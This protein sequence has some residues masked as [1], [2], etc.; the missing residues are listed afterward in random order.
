MEISGY[1][2]SLFLETPPD[3]F[4][5]AICM[6]V[7]RN[8]YQCQNGHMFCRQCITRYL[9]IAPKCPTCKFSLSIEI[10]S[11]CLVVRNMVGK[12]LTRCTTTI[13][14]ND[15]GVS[16]EWRGNIDDLSEHAKVCEFEIIQ[17]ANEGCDFS[18][19]RRFFD[20]HELECEY[21]LI[22]CQYCETAIRRCNQISHDEQCTQRPMDCPNDCGVQISGA[23]DMFVH[24]GEC[25]LQEVD[26]PFV[27]VGCSPF[28][29]RR[30][31]RRDLGMH[32]SDPSTTLSTMRALVRKIG[33]LEEIRMQDSNRIRN[34]EH[35]NTLL[36]MHLL[37][38]QDPDSSIIFNQEM[39]KCKV[40]NDEIWST[41]HIAWE[42]QCTEIADSF[43]LFDLF[44]PKKELIPDVF[45]C[46]NIDITEPLGP[47][48]CYAQLDGFRRTAEYSITIFRYGAGPPKQRVDMKKWDKN[49]GFGWASFL[50]QEEL[51]SGGYV[52]AD[53]KMRILLTISMEP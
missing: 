34:L 22:V 35:Q 29:P 49:Q 18:F 48:R 12:L 50:S 43:K 36:S 9:A 26:C 46:I 20:Y 14:T 3:D 42:V 51:L 53:F 21:K 45:G 28:C 8:P 38:L 27:S 24:R 4:H 6:E 2:S 23:F 17:C 5:C 39:Q 40:V 37:S 33:K 1:P 30:L 13:S 47:L 32:L 44:S 52:T 7:L 31:L 41:H 16:C 11:N 19:Q 10:L 25:P 15:D